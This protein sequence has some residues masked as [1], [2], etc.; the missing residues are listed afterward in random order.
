[1]CTSNECTFG[2]CEILSPTS[3]TCHCNIGITGKNCNI[4]STDNSNPCASNPCYNSAVCSNIQQQFICICQSGYGGLLCKG[5]TNSCQCQNGGTCTTINFNGTNVN[6]CKCPNG[7][8][9]YIL[10]FLNI[11]I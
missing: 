4:R 8:G 1:M 7:Y 3:Y 6:E 11:F 9:Y 10:L 5:T 2:T